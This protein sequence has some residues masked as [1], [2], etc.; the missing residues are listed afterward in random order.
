MNN[1]KIITLNII[2]LVLDILPI[3][4]LISGILYLIFEAVSDS[5][6]SDGIGW[7]LF[8]MILASGLI[9]IPFGTETILC[10]LTLVFTKNKVS[11]G[12][13]ICSVAS[14]IVSFIVAIAVISYIYSTLIE[15]NLSNLNNILIGIIA[16]LILG[17]VV[18]LLLSIN[19]VSNKVKKINT[20][21]SR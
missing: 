18:S 1:K 14:S 21:N 13:C 6:A 10:I 8:I 5:N 4:A 11:T 12:A 19:V 20:G 15:G 7:A 9:L 3:L 17:F 16:Y 2:S